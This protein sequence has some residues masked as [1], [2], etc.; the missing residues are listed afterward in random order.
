MHEP[1]A[2]PAVRFQP[3]AHDGVALGGPV[4]L[5]AAV[6]EP[7]VEARAAHAE[8]AG[9]QLHG[10]FGLL[11]QH[12]AVARGYAWSLAK[13]A[14][15]FFQKRVLHLEL[16]DAPSGLAQLAVLGLGVGLAGELAPAPY[17]PLVDHLG[18]EAQ[19]PA[20]FRYGPS[21]RCDVVGGLAPELVGVL[22]DRVRHD[23]VL[24]SSLRCILDD[25]SL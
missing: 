15:T 11:R 10:E 20:A 21:R 19:F 1:E 12:E 16:A 24:S 9:H 22:G 23:I 8:H 7:R 25:S 3:H 2:E 14:A 5:R 17:H 18:V 4:V 6:R 13:K